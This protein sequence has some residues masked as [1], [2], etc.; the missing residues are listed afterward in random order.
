MFQRLRL[1]KLTLPTWRYPAA[2]QHLTAQKES[3]SELA[4]VGAM[5]AGRAFDRD[6]VRESTGDPLMEKDW[7]RKEGRT[8]FSKM[9]LP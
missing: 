3:A 5:N 4:A 7:F 1:G 9:V 2:D 6:I 8:C